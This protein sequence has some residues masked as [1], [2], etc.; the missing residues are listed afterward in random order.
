MGG[1]FVKFVAFLNVASLG[2]IAWMMMAEV[3]A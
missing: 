3:L 1:G 2:V